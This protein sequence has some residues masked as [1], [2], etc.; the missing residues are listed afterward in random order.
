MAV[1]PEDADEV[2]GELLGTLSRFG[3][4]NER[5]IRSLHS[6]AVIVDEMDRLERDFA[7]REETIL[8]MGI[9]TA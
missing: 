7:G 9:S 1:W 8:V 4:S 6:A 2:V 5:A 3:C